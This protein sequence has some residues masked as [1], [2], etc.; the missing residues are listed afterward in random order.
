[1]NATVRY[2]AAYPTTPTQFPN[3]AG[4]LDVDLPTRCISHSFS[5]FCHSTARL[6]VP[7]LRTCYVSRLQ[8]PPRALP[9]VT[10][11]SSTADALAHAPTH[12]SLLV[13]DIH[14]FFPFAAA[15]FISLRTYAPPPP[16]T[17]PTFNIPPVCALTPCGPD[18]TGALTLPPLLRT[19]YDLALPHHR[20]PVAPRA[21]CTVRCSTFTRLL[22]VPALTI[23]FLSV[24]AIIDGY[25]RICS[26]CHHLLWFVR[27]TSFL[28]WTILLP[29]ALPTRTPLRAGAAPLPLPTLF[30]PL[31]RRAPGG[32]RWEDLGPQACLPCRHRHLP[33]RTA[34]R[35]CASL[36]VCSRTRA[37]SACTT[38]ARL[39]PYLLITP[40]QCRHHCAPRE[41]THRLLPGSHSCFIHT[42]VA[43][44]P[45]HTHLP[46][47]P[48]HCPAH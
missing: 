21:F 33:A 43:A 4:T 10:L 3:T 26:S 22:R 2:R 1:M 46:G 19:H 25:Y 16:R 42:R 24:V 45:F 32:L 39:S 47:S 20:A 23:S 28:F 13:C 34:P 48:I 40:P 30:R 29:H 15:T 36:L 7:T 5:L 18:P 31:P 37:S 17:L 44:F 38:T 11:P 35:C 9:C 6:Q 14:Q 41:V 12:I 8:P 27:S